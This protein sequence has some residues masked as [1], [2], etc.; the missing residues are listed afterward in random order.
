M[1]L[2]ILFCATFFALLCECTAIYDPI[3]KLYW[4]EAEELE[5]VDKSGCTDD[6]RKEYNFMTRGLPLVFWETSLPQSTLQTQCWKDFQ[7]I[8][9]SMK[10]GCTKALKCE[11]FPFYSFSVWPGSQS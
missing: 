8:Q 11:W 2:Y 5:S 9:S 4:P 7:H 10:S 6:F 1:D 3:Y